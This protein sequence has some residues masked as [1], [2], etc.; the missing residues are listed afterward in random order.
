MFHALLS[1][2][3]TRAVDRISTGPWK[4]QDGTPVPRKAD[5]ATGSVL[6]NR[7][8]SGGVVPNGDKVWTGSD[9][10]G[11][12]DALTCAGWTDGQGVGNG[13]AGSIGGAGQTWISSDNQPC[14]DSRAIYCFED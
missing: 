14:S 2:P 13:R 7:D 11:G 5:F 9:G 3:G 4:L 6:V 10:T 1:S 12:P 8:A